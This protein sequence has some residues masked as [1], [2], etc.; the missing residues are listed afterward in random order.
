MRRL[1]GTSRPWLL[2]QGF[3]FHT[4]GSSAAA[5]ST[6]LRVRPVSSH[7]QFCGGG[8][9]GGVTSQLARCIPPLQRPSRP[10]DCNVTRSVDCR[11]RLKP[12]HQL[13]WGSAQPGAV[14][15]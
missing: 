14:R 7:N 2:C 11:L 4:P 1:V 10:R 3:L 8:G 12:L 13:W 9:G 6:P 5:W 15:P